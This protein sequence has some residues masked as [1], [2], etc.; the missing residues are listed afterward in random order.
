VKVEKKVEKLA[1]MLG[2][3]DW[4]VVDSGYVCEKGER[5]IRTLRRV[6]LGHSNVDDVYNDIKRDVQDVKFDK[7]V[8]R[9]STRHGHSRLF[10]IK[11]NT[12]C[13]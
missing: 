1:G 9:V 4:E 12:V 3:R 13:S 8:Y 7:I 6:R 2:V 10:L 11:K 5:I